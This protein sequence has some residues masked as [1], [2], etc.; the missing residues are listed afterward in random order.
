MPSTCVTMTCLGFSIV[1]FPVH[2]RLWL[3]HPPWGEVRGQGAL[4]RSNPQPQQREAYKQL[5]QLTRHDDATALMTLAQ[6]ETSEQIK[7]RMRHGYTTAL[8]T[9]AFT[10]CTVRSSG[11]QATSHFHTIYRKTTYTSCQKHS[12][13]TRKHEQN[14]RYSSRLTNVKQTNSEPL[15]FKKRAIHIWT[16]VQNSATCAAILFCLILP[17]QVKHG[18]FSSQEQPISMRICE[19]TTARTEGET[20][21]ISDDG[22]NTRVEYQPSRSSSTYVLPQKRKT[23]HHLHT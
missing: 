17:Q 14:E 5:K 2:E 10:A 23:T 8:K 7:Q 11:I 13:G 4:R 18:S 16:T 21:S 15:V 22:I 3:Q 1:D 6:Y 9:V 12:A 19:T 20:R